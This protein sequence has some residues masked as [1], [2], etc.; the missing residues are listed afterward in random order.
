VTTVPAFRTGNIGEP[1]FEALLP[2]AAF[3]Q[4]EELRQDRSEA[5]GRM[6]G[7]LPNEDAQQVRDEIDNLARKLKEEQQLLTRA[8]S[9]E[10]RASRTAEVEKLS[11]RLEKKRADLAKRQGARDRLYETAVQ[12]LGNLVDR[13]ERA[14]VQAGGNFF[15]YEGAQAKPKRGET[16]YAAIERVRAEREDIR[17]NLDL[18]L[19]APL[20][21]SEALPAV[22]RYLDKLIERGRP[23]FIEAI[24]RQTI[25]LRYREDGRY[26]WLDGE[27]PIKWPEVVC[28]IGNT[29]SGRAASLPDSNALIAWLLPDLF[30]QRC[31]DEVRAR[32]DEG[33]ALTA[34]DRKARI[35]DLVAELERV[36]REEESF[37]R[38]TK[39]LGQPITRRIDATVEIVLGLVIRDRY[40]AFGVE[41]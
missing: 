16:L 4:L 21:L 7:A 15:L 10:Q 29:N 13:I 5:R 40:A 27:R 28:N 1:D 19:H 22:D 18:A 12:P 8:M 37:I 14:V 2:P 34:V 3:A 17:H 36:E 23:D 24:E 33:H 38:A 35:A 26:G 39:E 30:R 41:V 20:P 11:V 6:A 31:H 9:E 25:D 32:S